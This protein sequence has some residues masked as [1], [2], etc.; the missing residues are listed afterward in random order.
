MEFS[1]FTQNRTIRLIHTNFPMKSLFYTLLFLGIFTAVGCSSSKDVTF[2][3]MTNVRMKSLETNGTLRIT[4]DAVLNN[5]RRVKAKVTYMECAISINGEQLVEMAQS[6]E[7]KVPKRSDFPVSF[8][9]SVS[10]K[11]VTEN[12][13]SITKSVLWDGKVDTKMTGVLKVKVFGKTFTIPFEFEEEMPIS[14]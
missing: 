14:L 2:K 12:L 4:A 8:E 3:E 6:R 10:L 7:A 11:K 1:S 13:M 5:P 9:T